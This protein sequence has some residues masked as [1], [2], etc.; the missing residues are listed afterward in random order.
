ME[1][2]Q[3]DVVALIRLFEYLADEARRL[4][5]GEVARQLDKPLASL[6]AEVQT[7]FGE[8]LLQESDET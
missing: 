5:F 1:H 6:L 8:R 7:R 4:D 3:K 2:D